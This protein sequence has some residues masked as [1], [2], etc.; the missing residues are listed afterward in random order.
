MLT[1]SLVDP[2]RL[3]RDALRALLEKDGE[4]VVAAEGCN[5]DDAIRIAERVRPE[6][7]LLELALP[8][9][10]GFELIRRLT[11][12][13]T[14]KTVVM[15]SAGNGVSAVE[16]LRHGAL[17]CVL[18]E[19]GSDELLQALR[20]AAIGEPYVSRHLRNRTLMESLAQ[21]LPPKREANLTGRERAVL[22]LVAEGLTNAEAAERL[23]I[24]RRTVESHRANL[25]QK[26]GLK[27]QADLVRYAIRNQ[28]IQP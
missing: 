28:I 19:D 4:F 25:M 2:Q 21:S 27:T 20:Q 17:A 1:I 6:I 22:E 26:L 11:G 15:T 23:K 18:K 5:G 13:V 24:S 16:A 3:F 9:S 7:L 14:M 10:H 12:R 8:E